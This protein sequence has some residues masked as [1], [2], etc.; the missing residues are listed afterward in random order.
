MRWGSPSWCW[1]HPMVGL[2]PAAAFP[3][4][5]LW[6]R[7]VS[8]LPWV[9]VP[10]FSSLSAWKRSGNVPYSLTQK[11]LS[12]HHVYCGQQHVRRFTGEHLMWNNLSSVEKFS[13]CRCAVFIFFFSYAIHITSQYRELRKA[14]VFQ[15]AVM[16]SI[17]DFLSICDSLSRTVYTKECHKKEGKLPRTAIVSNLRTSFSWSWFWTQKSNFQN[18]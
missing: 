3:L 9:H 12:L 2:C 15:K 8:L 6:Q 7:L 11:L 17:C 16:R 1:E 13:V 5:G 4:R 18:F 10:R 14:A